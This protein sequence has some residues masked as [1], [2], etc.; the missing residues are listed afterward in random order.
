MGAEN[1][2]GLVQPVALYRDVIS[3]SSI[4]FHD[5]ATNLDFS[6]FL[7]HP[8]PPTA[9]DFSVDIVSKLACRLVKP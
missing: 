2:C 6:L 8:G 3:N 7:T 1:Y 4:S 9:S 5:C